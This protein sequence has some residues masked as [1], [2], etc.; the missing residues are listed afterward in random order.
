MATRKVI[1]GKTLTL[2]KLVTL[3][4]VYWENQTHGFK[5]DDLSNN[6]FHFDWIMTWLREQEHVVASEEEIFNA[7]KTILE[8]WAKKNPGVNFKIEYGGIDFPNEFRISFGII[9]IRPLAR[10]K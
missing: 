9:P 4:K 5:M 7:H 1:T 8:D 6:Y 10:H 2:E 3:I